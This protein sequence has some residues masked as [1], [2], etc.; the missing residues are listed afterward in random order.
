MKILAT[1]AHY[2]D[3][4]I[5]CGGTLLKHIKK[6]DEVFFGITSSD[7]FR[8]G[9][10]SVRKHE[11]DLS[12]KIMGISDIYTFSYNEEV[13]DIIGKLDSISPNIIFTQHEFDTHQDHRRASIIGQ[14]IGRKRN[15]T[16]L[17]YDSGASYDFHPNIFSL[18][19]FKEKSKLMN[20]YKSQIDLGAVN[21]DII[22]K[23]E[24]YWAS[25]VSNKP[26]AYAEGF[27][28][29]KMIYEV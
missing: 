3:I 11:Q 29:K 27:L 12:A 14:A 22:K 9:H 23:K 26:E 24:M 16:T 5:G 1:G 28:L 7:E 17:F 2:D 20:C 15:I 13:H 19:D 10:I 8:T 4:E 6:G 21:L 25:L 18:V